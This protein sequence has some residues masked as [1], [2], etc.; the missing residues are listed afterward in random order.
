[1]RRNFGEDSDFVYQNKP[2]KGKLKLKKEWA[3]A[4]PILYGWKRWEDFA[5]Q[6]SFWIK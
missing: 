5:R 2:R 4:V 6:K 1:M 3:D